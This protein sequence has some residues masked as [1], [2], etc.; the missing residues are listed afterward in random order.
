MSAKK[1]RIRMQVISDIPPATHQRLTDV[2]ARHGL[3]IAK[4]GTVAVETYLGYLEHG[5][6]AVVVPAELLQ[7]LIDAARADQLSVGAWVAGVVREH[8]LARGRI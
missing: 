4:L 1:S 7:P 6:A 3:S 2:C 8:L 5:Q